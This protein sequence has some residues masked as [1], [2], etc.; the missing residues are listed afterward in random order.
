ML[1]LNAFLLS[2]LAAILRRFIMESAWQFQP[3]GLRPFIE[4]CDV[5]A[6]RII[7]RLNREDAGNPSDEKL[8]RFL[9]ELLNYHWDS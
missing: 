3:P 6:A 9:E 7:Q 1:A 5:V 4:N 2:F 8:K